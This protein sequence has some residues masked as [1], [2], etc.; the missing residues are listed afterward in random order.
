MSRFIPL[1]PQ[2]VGTSQVESLTS[3]VRRLAQVEVRAVPDLLTDFVVAPLMRER[4]Q[5]HPILQPTRMTESIN[6]TG[7]VAAAL[8]D[9]LVALT[10]LEEIRACSLVGSDGTVEFRE[11][12]RAVR[13]WCPR[14]LWEDSDRPY[15][16]LAWALTP[17]SRCEVHGTSLRNR[18]RSCGLS[19]RPWHRAAVPDRCAHCSA[20]LAAPDRRACASPTRTVSD[21]LLAV[22]SREADRQSVAA[23]FAH[24]MAHLGGLGPASLQLSV[25]RSELCGLRRGAIRPHLRLLVRAIE[26]SGGTAAGFLSQPAPT[27][28]K[29]HG[30]RPPG[31]HR[32][33]A[34]LVRTERALSKHP[35]ISIRRLAR[36]VGTTPATLR[37]LMPERTA[38][39][40]TQTRLSNQQRRARHEDRLRGRVLGAVRA[41][42]ETG[43]VRRRDV[44][45][46][47]G[48]GGV[49]RSALARR[50]LRSALAT[51]PAWPPR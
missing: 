51:F 29:G 47:L 26:L 35:T 38:A 30:G 18:C 6:G 5:R 2:G 15:D 41:V 20:R 8:V 24:V 31:R 16:R 37:R 11:A 25:S 43:P 22:R 23:G 36:I 27:L 10:A 49:L 28:I 44:E 4:G 1:Q 21:I 39:L 42:A 40:L 34:T 14:C 48:A 19:H 46:A 7:R 12:W 45:R 32:A 13:A 9:R 17:S 33:E 50:T 3:Y